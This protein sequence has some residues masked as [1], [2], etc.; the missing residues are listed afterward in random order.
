MMLLSFVDGGLGTPGTSSPVPGAPVRGA[1]GEPGESAATAVPAFDEALDASLMPDDEKT[2]AAFEEAAAAAIPAV[3]LPPP[4]REMLGA[5]AAGTVGSGQ[6]PGVS[7]EIG[8]A[9]DDVA[10]DDSS[11]EQTPSVRARIAIPL[12]GI[13]RSGVT[14]REALA[15]DAAVARPVDRSATDRPAHIGSFETSLPHGGGVDVAEASPGPN[16]GVD[17]GTPSLDASREAVTGLPVRAP[18]VTSDAAARGEQ[19]GGVHAATQTGAGTQS[20][21]PPEADG[22][23]FARAGASPSPAR[24]AEDVAAA[25]SARDAAAAS[26][27]FHVDQGAGD[28]PFDSGANAAADTDGGSQGHAADTRAGVRFNMP[29]AEPSAG[30]S[31]PGAG[32]FEVTGLGA[33]PAA[34]RA[35]APAASLSEAAAGPSADVPDADT[36]DRLV[37]SLRLQFYRGGGEAVVHIRPEHLGPLKVSLRVERGLVTARVNADNPAVAEWL[38][39][40]EQTLREAMQANGLSLE[41]LIVDRDGQQGQTP[42]R[43]RPSSRRE[44]RHGERGESTFEIT[45]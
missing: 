12:D 1:R 23:A 41:R 9:V 44:S 26:A 43:D 8:S 40:N 37:Q 32:A 25:R 24:G 17:A 28:V 14:A 16:G 31:A 36:M 22:A 13:D 3:L 2:S 7:G 21:A 35:D 42:H 30:T 10:P 39:A 5:H 18:A 15:D 6:E 27:A 34:L 45:V 29:A 33:A 38:Q 20:T 19:P 4:A 11:G